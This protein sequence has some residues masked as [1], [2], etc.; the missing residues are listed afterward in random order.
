MRLAPRTLAAMLCAA[1][2]AGCI[3]VPP[4]SPEP[5]APPLPAPEPAADPVPQTPPPPPRVSDA[6]R[7]LY[8][9]EYLLELPPEQ[10]A[11]EA[12]RTQRFFA[13]HRSEFALMQLVLLR[14]L[15]GAPPR[16]RM[17]ALDTLA[18][19]LKE[20]RDRP[21][22]LRPFAL[23]V[24]NLLAEQQRLDVEL[25]AQTQKVKDEARRYEEL[26][27]KLD[28]LIETERKMLERTKPTRTQ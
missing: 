4:V 13:Q 15:P 20:T 17:Q 3:P 22:E 14:I 11:R 12:E 27:Q 6:E 26:R 19:Y 2:L 25:Q 7:L 1:C 23:F 28:A 10:V 9:Y 5:P 8:Y 24:N 21:S 18:Q 16:D